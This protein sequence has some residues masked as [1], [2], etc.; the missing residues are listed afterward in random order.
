MTEGGGQST[1]ERAMDKARRRGWWTQRDGNRGRRRQ[2]STQGES[3]GNE[4]LT[5]AGMVLF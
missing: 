5:M 3:N 4:G 1:T 2:G